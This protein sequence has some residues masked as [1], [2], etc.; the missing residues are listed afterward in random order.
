MNGEGVLGWRDR[1]KF[2]AALQETTHTNHRSHA[3]DAHEHHQ[4]SRNSEKRRDKYLREAI[5]FL[6]KHPVGLGSS[7]RKILTDKPHTLKPLH[8]RDRVPKRKG[9]EGDSL[10]Q[11]M[12]LRALKISQKILIRYL[13]YI[14]IF[15]Q[16]VKT[17]RYSIGNSKLDKITN[18][19]LVFL[20]GDGAEYTEASYLVYGLQFCRCKIAKHDFLVMSKLSLGG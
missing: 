2:L 7:H 5:R 1:H 3:E 18:K 20:Y 11:D 10:S 6:A 13:Q 4:Q 15:E 19:Y 8:R 17:Y 12:M 14:R 9:L 16:W